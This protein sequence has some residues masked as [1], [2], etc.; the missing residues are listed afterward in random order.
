MSQYNFWR[1]AL[2]S[3]YLVCYDIADSKRL[4][5]ARKLVYQ[6]AFGGQRSALECYLT[7]ES[8]GIIVDG[9]SKIIKPKIDRVNIVE[10]SEEVVLLGGAER[11]RLVDGVVEL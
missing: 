4:Y 11:I 5:R 8:L 2:T 1:C 10:V 7:K 9:L 3:F 6:Y